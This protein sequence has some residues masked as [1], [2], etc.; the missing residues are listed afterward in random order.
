MLRSQENLKKI[1]TSI[2]TLLVTACNT[3]HPT[4]REINFFF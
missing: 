4:G 1:V 2:K 3:L